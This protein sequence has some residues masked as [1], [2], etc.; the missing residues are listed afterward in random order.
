ML[1]AGEHCIT[2]LGVTTISQEFLRQM[3]EYPLFDAT[4]LKLVH[5]RYIKFKRN[6]RWHRLDISNVDKYRK[7][8]CATI[9]AIFQEL[10][11]DV[12]YTPRTVP[13]LVTLAKGRTRELR[14]IQRYPIP[15]ERTIVAT[16][17][18]EAVLSCYPESAHFH[19]SVFYLGNRDMWYEYCDIDGDPPSSKQL[20]HDIRSL[21][22]VIIRSKLSTQRIPSFISEFLAQR[23]PHQ[24]TPHHAPNQPEPH[25]A[26]PR[27]SAPRREPIPPSEPLSPIEREQPIDA[28]LKPHLPEPPPIIQHA[29]P[30]STKPLPPIDDMTQRINNYV[31]SPQFQQNF[32]MK[33]AE[34]RLQETLQHLTDD[35]RANQLWTTFY[36]LITGDISPSAFYESL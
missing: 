35:Q 10:F 13:C 34:W 12:Q 26:L 22:D 32:I 5:D 2:A 18:R 29:E 6:G 33:A 20:F 25:D 19:L 9:I 14:Y 7:S 31:A 4:D 11:V 23:L 8:T 24:S 21:H 16:G 1:Y 15:D 28:P 30:S 17:L 36:R 3:T 27:I